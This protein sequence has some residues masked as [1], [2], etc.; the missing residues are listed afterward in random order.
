MGSMVFNMFSV[1]IGSKQNI[2]NMIF[3]NEEEEESSTHRCGRL[4][5]YWLQ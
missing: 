2:E 3:S 4:G 1:S 5:L